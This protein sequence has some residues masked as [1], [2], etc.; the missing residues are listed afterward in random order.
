MWWPEET[1]APHGQN[2]GRQSRA[3]RSLLRHV[4]RESPNAHQPY[5]QWLN[6][7]AS[8]EEWGPGEWHQDAEGGWWWKPLHNPVAYAAAYNQAPPKA[9]PPKAAPPKAAPPKAAPA[10][11]ARPKPAEP[12]RPPPLWMMHRQMRQQMQMPPQA[13]RFIYPTAP[14]HGRQQ[15]AVGAD[16]TPASAAATSHHPEAAQPRFVVPTPKAGSNMH[17]G[18]SSSS[19]APPPVQ[20]APSPRQMAAAVPGSFSPTVQSPTEEYD[21]WGPHRPS[22]KQEFEL[23]EEEVVWEALDA[24]EEVAWYWQRQ[25]AKEQEDEEMKEED[26]PVQAGATSETHD[27]Q[28]RQLFEAIGELEE[29]AA[30][31]S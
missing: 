7:L 26:E 29:I 31:T 19:Q 1:N 16:A 21:P 27:E 13:P 15:A 11:A 10:K 5:Q 6:D 17:G 12:S 23:V 8:E 30:M 20:E 28:T 22:E 18:S 4:H 9:A 24:A 14:W 25:E 3:V 2:H